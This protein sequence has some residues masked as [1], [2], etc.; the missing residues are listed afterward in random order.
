MIVLRTSDNVQ[1]FSLQGWFTNT[2]PNL[3][4]KFVIKKMPLGA[5]FD[6]RNFGLKLTQT[7]RGFYQKE[8]LNL[9]GGFQDANK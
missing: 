8:G 9:I 1:A 6:P 5:N 3:V 2:I 4:K 7:L